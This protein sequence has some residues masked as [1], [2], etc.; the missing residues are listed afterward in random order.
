MKNKVKQ[1]G[2]VLAMCIAF[3][4]TGS[5]IAQ[6]YGGSAYAYVIHEDGTR[7]VI[8]VVIFANERTESDA[9]A[10]LSADIHRLKDTYKEEFD[11]K[12]W[13]SINRV[14][15]WDKRYGGTATVRI[16]NTKTGKERQIN[17]DINCNER[18]IPD[19][20]NKLLNDIHRLKHTYDEVFIQNV[21]YDIDGCN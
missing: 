2:K 12:I 13:Y 15:V 5:A 7:R 11:G 8:N 9:K 20:K 4:T 16:K 18:S 6:D 10:K 19:A 17:V 3:F 21:V 14:D 1:M